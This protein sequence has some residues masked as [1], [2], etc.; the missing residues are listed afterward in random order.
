MDSAARDR[1]VSSLQR[2]YGSRVGS[3]EVEDA[4]GHMLERLAK[5]EATEIDA[6]DNPT[7][8]LFVGMRNRLNERLRLRSSSEVRFD[9]LEGIDVLD[10]VLSDDDDVV[11]GS[12]LGRE[13]AQDRLADVAE[14]VWTKFTGTDAQIAARILLEEEKPQAVAAELGLDPA[15][16]S[17]VAHLAHQAHRLL[18]KKVKENPEFRC[19][20]LRKHMTAYF[21]TGEVSLALRAHWHTCAKCKAAERAAQQHTRNVL[22]PFLPAGAMLAGGGGVFSHLLHHATAP[23]R[24]AR[25]LVRPLTQSGAKAGASSSQLTSI[26]ATVTAKTAVIATTAVLATGAAAATTVVAVKHFSHHTPA[27]AVRT[28]TAPAVT[29]APVKPTVTHPVTTTTPHKPAKHVTKRASKPKKH[30]VKKKRRHVATHTTVTPPPAVQTTPATTPVVTTPVVTTPATSTTTVAPTT[31][32]TPP[33][34]THTTTSA[35]SS[36]NG[37]VTNPSYQTPSAP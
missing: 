23:A 36:S 17:K 32:A 1:I 13:A 5:M 15:H 14:L 25:R 19:W 37:Q 3:D 6:I 11:V 21:D 9:D 20:R 30:H 28:Y 35:S 4:Y 26:G 16:V 18:E 29:H 12:L 8:W 7:T 31:T 33:P 34:A 24:A 22:A 2:Q 27:P 10:D